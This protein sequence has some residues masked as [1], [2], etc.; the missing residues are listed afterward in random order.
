MIKLWYGTTQLLGSLTL[1]VGILT[2]NIFI[3]LACVPFFAITTLFL[4]YDIVTSFRRW[5]R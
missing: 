2:G 5:N 1:L 4:G 3:L